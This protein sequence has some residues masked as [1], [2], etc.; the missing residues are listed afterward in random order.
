MIST[1][2]KSLVF[3][4]NKLFILVFCRKSGTTHLCT[5][6][7]C[8]IYTAPRR[9]HFQHMVV[10]RL[11]SLYLTVCGCGRGSE[12]GACHQ[13]PGL[14][15]RTRYTNHSALMFFAVGCT[16]LDLIKGERSGPSHTP[17]RAIHQW[18][19]P[20]DKCTSH[21]PIGGSLAYGR[22]H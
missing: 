21:W 22:S 9:A 14:K 11:T 18:E 5:M 3:G 16:S 6:L 8:V 12:G 15:N 13:E 17:I 7:K 4:T 2:S 10:Y 1:L 20:I 19:T